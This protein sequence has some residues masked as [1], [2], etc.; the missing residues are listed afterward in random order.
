MKNIFRITVLV[1]LA[2]LLIGTIPGR[3]LNAQSLFSCSVKGKTFTGNIQDAE[4]VT[5]NKEKVIQLK[6][7]DGSKMMYL[8]L[9]TSKIKTVPA[10][11]KYFEHDPAKGV[12]PESEIIWVPDGPDNPQWNSVDG[13]VVVTLFDSAKKT[14]SGTFD[15]KV[16]KFEYT[17][18]ENKERPSMQITDG[19]FT[20]ITYKEAL[21]QGK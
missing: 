10:T 15:F 5:M 6:I 20:N 8:Y 11:L 21:A 19:K 14:I 2:L 18:D 3:T 12:S 13:E 16:E 4:L 17:S 7:A 9:K 1:S